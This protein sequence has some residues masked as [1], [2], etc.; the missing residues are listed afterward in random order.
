MHRITKAYGYI[1]FDCRMPR[2]W[3]MAEDPDLLAVAPECT[4]DKISEASCL[5][6]EL[7]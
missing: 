4:P 1:D 7:A 6:R 3:W 2:N 5:W